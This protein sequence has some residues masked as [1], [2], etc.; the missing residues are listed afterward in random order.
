MNKLSISF[1]PAL[2]DAVRDSARHQGSSISAW[3][4]DAA[5]AKL[6]AE[7]LVDYL[8]RWEAAHGALSTEELAA[9]A[10]ELDMQQ[11]VASR[12]A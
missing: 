5:A 3:L 11:A 4:A 9:A 6:R 1:D 10:A 12:A 2:G 8:E 7:A